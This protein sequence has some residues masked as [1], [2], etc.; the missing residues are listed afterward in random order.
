MSEAER[1][2]NRRAIEALRAGVPNRDAVLALGSTQPEIERKFLRATSD[3]A[4]PRD[5]SLPQGMLV[6]GGFGAGK[7]HLLEFLSTNSPKRKFCV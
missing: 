3:P 6:K 5:G 4:K 7:S 2:R 1:M